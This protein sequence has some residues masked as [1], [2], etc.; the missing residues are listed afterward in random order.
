MQSDYVESIKGLAAD[1]PSL[2]VPAIH[3]IHSNRLR[4]TG[5]I[6][7]SKR[8]NSVLCM[9]VVSIHKSNDLSFCKPLHFGYAN[10]PHR[11]LR[12]TSF[13]ICNGDADRSVVAA[14]RK[15]STGSSGFGL[16]DSYRAGTYSKC[17]D[18]LIQAK[19]I[20]TVIG[21]VPPVKSAITSSSSKV[22]SCS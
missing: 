11:F 6:Q 4:G 18:A 21:F 2:G 7:I 9:I 20:P 22:P 17:R 13:L 12:F 16:S 15:Y 1:C 8:N 14:L 3:P 5:P 19:I 10:V